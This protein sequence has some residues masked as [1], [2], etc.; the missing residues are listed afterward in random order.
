MIKTRRNDRIIKVERRT[1]IGDAWR[2][3]EILRD[4]GVVLNGLDGETIK[5][6]L[7]VLK[8]GG[9]LIS[10]SGPSD[11][12]SLQRTLDWAGYLNW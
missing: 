4:C 6:S 3:E 1:L 10:I 9:N 5:K 8:P 12:A 7:R 2:F 11:P